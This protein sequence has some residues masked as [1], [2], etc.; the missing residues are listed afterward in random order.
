MQ[1]SSMQKSNCNCT[2][3]W[4]T[5]SQRAGL[6]YLF[7]AINLTECLSFRSYSMCRGFDRRDTPLICPF[8]RDPSNVAVFNRLRDSIHHIERLS[9]WVRHIRSGVEAMIP[10][11]RAPDTRSGRVK[12]LDTCLALVSEDAMAVWLE[13]QA[14]VDLSQWGRG[15][16]KH[17]A[18]L[19]KE[20]RAPPNFLADLTAQADRNVLAHARRILRILH[21]LIDW[22][23]W[24]A[25]HFAHS[26][27]S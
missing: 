10:W 3:K 1:E 24:R 9:S 19:L 13:R 23:P 5:R 12:Y 2:C 25:R 6:V 20:V 4:L 26:T 14:N 17:V 22:R 21:R 8:S 11:L 27:P 15:K 16:A 7:F 18:D